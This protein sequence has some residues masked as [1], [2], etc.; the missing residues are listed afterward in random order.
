L[1]NNHFVNLVNNII[2]VSIFNLSRQGNAY[3]NIVRTYNRYCVSWQFYLGCSSYQCI[4]ALVKQISTIH[5]L[6]KENG[7]LVSLFIIE[8]FFIYSRSSFIRY[9]KGGCEFI[10]FIRHNRLVLNACYLDV[11]SSSLFQ[12]RSKVNGSYFIFVANAVARNQ[13]TVFICDFVVCFTISTYNIFTKSQGH[14]FSTYYFQFSYRRFCSISYYRNCCAQNL[15]VFVAKVVLNCFFCNINCQIACRQRIFKGN[16]PLCFV[17]TRNFHYLFCLVSINI[18]SV[19]NSFFA[20]TS[21][22][23]IEGKYYF[24]LGFCCAG[25]QSRRSSV[26]CYSEWDVRFCYKETCTVF[27]NLISI[28]VHSYSVIP[29]GQVTCF[30]NDGFRC[31][32]KIA[33]IYRILTTVNQEANTGGSKYWFAKEYLHFT[34]SNQFCFN[35]LRKRQVQESYF[36]TEIRDFLSSVSSRFDV[37]YGQR[38][39]FLL[40]SCYSS[41]IKSQDYSFAVYQSSLF[42]FY[43]CSANS[44]IIKIFSRFLIYSCA[45]FH[46]NL[47]SVKS[48]YAL[49]FQ[50]ATIYRRQ[51]VFILFRIVGT[52]TVYDSVRILFKVIQTSRFH[53]FA[54]I[55]VCRQDVLERSSITISV[56]IGGAVQII[57]NFVKR[58][59]KVIKES[60]DVIVFI[61]LAANVKASVR[62]R[63]SGSSHA[64]YNS[65]REYRKH[66]LFVHVL[67]LQI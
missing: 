56:N 44:V 39:S 8:T 14:A 37:S 52:S 20:Q 50:L 53:H 47:R 64:C 46:F 59:V 63:H 34:R 26:F 4:F 65:C 49:N 12:G 33:T 3:R 28:R 10:H 13:L 5:R 61:Y 16:F 32:I 36:T 17:A 9:R 40:Q 30:Q 45:E 23:L 48:T 43:I 66:K 31:I 18:C 62:L 11:I 1:T 41:G 7:D 6:A 2:T 38:C 51:Q 24:L 29:Q 35:C 21:N 42:F 22:R 67:P 57:H 19:V 15:A 27:Y 55:A 54:Q 58:L 25:Y 60:I